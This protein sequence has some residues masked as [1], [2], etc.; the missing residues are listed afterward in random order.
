MFI[1]SVAA[2]TT[3]TTVAINA[4]AAGDFHFELLDLQGTVVATGDD[5]EPATEFRNIPAGQYTVTCCLRDVD[6]GTLGDVVSATVDTGAEAPTTRTEQTA[7]T[8]TV[9]VRPQQ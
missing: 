9:V 4:P 6:G 1:I 5:H 2:A 8:L 7:S 3:T